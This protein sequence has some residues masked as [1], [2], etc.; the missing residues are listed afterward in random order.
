MKKNVK[1]IGL[2][3]LLRYFPEKG[4]YDLWF[5]EPAKL[6]LAQRILNIF[7][8][9]GGGATYM[10][11]SYNNDVGPFLHLT[12]KYQTDSVKS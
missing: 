1:I 8:F 7:F 11:S 12:N 10:F 5:S 3:Y 9:L 6:V 2:S 4:G